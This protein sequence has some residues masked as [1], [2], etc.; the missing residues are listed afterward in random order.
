MTAYIHA[1]SVTDMKVCGLGL[2]NP[3]TQT[4][5]SDRAGKLLVLNDGKLDHFEPEDA[6][7]VKVKK[8]AGQY[9][10]GFIYILN[11]SSFR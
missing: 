7:T 9:S 3:T 10:K 6:S 11:M 2:R 8:H 4:L 5:V 1:F